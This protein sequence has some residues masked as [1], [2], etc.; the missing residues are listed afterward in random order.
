MIHLGA[1]GHAYDLEHVDLER[2]PIHPDDVL[3]LAKGHVLHAQGVLDVAGA[4]KLLPTRPWSIS[5]HVLGVDHLQPAYA[6]RLLHDPYVLVLR[7]LGDQ[8]VLVDQQLL[9]L[10]C[11][12]QL[13]GQSNI[14]FPYPP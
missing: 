5:I 12:E 14:V 6:H 11:A 1:R 9:K 7:V 10:F 2:V 3:Q 4:G 8:H 13:S